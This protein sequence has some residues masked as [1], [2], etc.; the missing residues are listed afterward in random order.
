MNF[1]NKYIY[2]A[3][4]LCSRFYMNWPLDQKNCVLHYSKTYQMLHIFYC[5]CFCIHIRFRKFFTELKAPTKAQSFS[6]ISSTC[7]HCS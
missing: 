5:I 2:S 6:N 3:V 7:Q 1:P 4:M